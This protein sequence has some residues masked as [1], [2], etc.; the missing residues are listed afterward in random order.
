LRSSA[1]RHAWPSI[2]AWRFFLSAILRRSR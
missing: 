2:K 1:S